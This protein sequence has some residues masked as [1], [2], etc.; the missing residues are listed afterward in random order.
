[1]SSELD[2]LLFRLRLKFQRWFRHRDI[3]PHRIWILVKTDRGRK[4]IAHYGLKT[5]RK[6]TYKLFGIKLPDH[7]DYKR[8]ASVNFPDKEQLGEFRDQASQFSYKPKI[9]VLLPVYNT[10]VKYLSEAIDSVLAQVY[11]N[12]ELCISDDNSPDKRIREVLQSYTTKDSRIKVCYRTINGHISANSNS[13]LELATGEYV[14][15]LDHDDLLTPDALFHNVQALN[16]NRNIDLIYSD[17]DK[18]HDNHVVSEPHF[19]PDWCPDNF[20]CRN[21]LG[22]LVVIR[23]DLVERAGRFREGFEGSQDYDLLLRVTELTEKIHH[24]PKVLYHWRMHGGSTSANESAKPYAF[25]SGIKALEEALARRG[26]KGKVSLID[27]LPGYYMIRYDLVKPGKVSIIMPSR[28]RADMCETA[29]ESVFRFTEYP[30]FELILVDNNSDEP[31]FFSMIERWKQK[32]PGRFKCIR[33]EGVFNFSRLINNGARA[34]NGSY[35]LLLNNDVEVISG[36][37]MTCMVEQ[38]Q[39]DQTGVVGVKLLYKSDIVQHAGVVIGLLGMV[40]HTFVGAP[41]DAPGYSYFL[42]AINNYSALTAACLMVRKSAFD[43]VGGFDEELAVEFN[44]VDFCL[45]LVEQGLRNIYVPHVTLYHYESISRGH[46]HSN[47]TAYKQHL[48]DVAIFRQRWQKY[49]DH[50]PCYSPNLTLERGDFSLR[51]VE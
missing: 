25:N 9:S 28:N 29:I 19:K 8:W 1:M 30:D 18:I 6:V 45:K 51:F 48:K 31:S 15:L 44:D 38:A 35:L 27:N 43:K 33:D 39:R 23:R 14:T 49:I 32:E 12:W 13:A 11:E 16:E 46:P 42:K 22:H 40:G 34:A 37:W 3:S 10:D 20:L 50:D 7:N 17:E 36:D 5:I 2:R 4:K 26:V 21:Y 24:I 47:S 41:K